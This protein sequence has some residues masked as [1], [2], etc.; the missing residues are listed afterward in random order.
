[1][2]TSTGDHSI[3]V[4]DLKSSYNSYTNFIIVYRVIIS[5]SDEDQIWI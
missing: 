3:S 2:I 1:M 4:R 5:D